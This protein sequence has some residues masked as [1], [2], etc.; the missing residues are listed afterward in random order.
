[1]RHSPKIAAGWLLFLV[2][3]APAQSTVAAVSAGASSTN[4]TPPP[5]TTSA[6]NAPADLG[7][8]IV[9]GQLEQARSEIVPDL[10]ATAYSVDKDQI[11]AE[12]QGADAPFNQVLLQTPGMAQDSLGQLHL[13][14]EHANLQ[15]RI[16]D[17]LLPEGVTGFGEELDRRF[18]DSLQIITGS[19]SAQY[20]FRTAGIVDIQ[21]K[22]GA[23]DP[24]GEV[25][26]EVGSYGTWRPSFEYGGADGK[27]NYYFEGSFDQN[28]IGIENP[29]PSAAPI[30]DLTNQIRSFADLSYVMS[31]IS[32]VSVLA[33]TSYGAFQLPDTPGLPAGISPNGDQWVPGNFNS[34]T[35][36]ENQIERN[37]YG[38]VAYQKS[39][40][41]LNFQLAAFGRFSSV[42]FSPDPTGD[43]YFDGV[44]GSVAREIFS[45]GLQNDLSY[46]LGDNHTLRAGWSV[47]EEVAPTDSD[48]TVFPTDSSGN[49]NGPAETIA[50]SNTVDAQFYGFY[51]QD[52]W[53]IT[54]KL[55]LNYGFRADYY[56]STVSE[57]QISPRINLIYKVDQTTTVHLGYARYF[58]PPPLE[59]VNQ[60]SVLQFAN[61]TNLPPG[62]VTQNSPVQA[63]RSHYFD[64]GITHKITPQWQAGLD[65]YYKIATNQLDDGFFGD[66]LIASSFN[67]AKG[68]VYGVELTTSYDNGGF[69][70]YANT[71]YSV[72][73]G[74]DITSAQFLFSAADLAYIQNHWVYLDHDQTVTAS[75]GVSYTWKHAPGN[76]RIFFDALAGSGL[77]K[78][79]DLPGG[80]TIP[81]GARVPTYFT[82]NAGI[83][84]EFKFGSGQ[85]LK[86]RLEVTNLLDRVYEL[87]N[88]SGIGVNAAQYGA[89]LGIF[90]TVSYSF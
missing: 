45:T 3:L 21:T 50:Q 62:S 28:E 61:T 36:N 11:D 40:G 60:E 9:V 38:I 12:P 89:R 29:T 10:G 82:L 24:G 78:D 13:R 7:D 67:Y 58:T 33:G 86:A 54:P 75:G 2:P 1:M 4:A 8:I 87:R 48:T 52:E 22:T 27:F 72:A 53:K 31:D 43:L 6:S 20:G 30:H 44:A 79:E 84:Q 14:G 85:F 47:L 25:S 42:L 18:V 17:V 34:S 49:P 68:Q 56:A 76:T 90:G 70:A 59:S 32:Q 26:L 35:L 88:G 37:D 51:L 64:A 74:E 65:G 63:E 77:R 69:S 15:Y 5:A 23:F 80:G 39:A 83:E 81:N 19:L 71:A 73:K 16:N 55:T 46:N 41:N 57:G 66:T